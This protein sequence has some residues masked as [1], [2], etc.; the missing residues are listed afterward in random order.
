MSIVH[1]A[2]KQVSW[3]ALFKLVSQIFSWLSTIIVARL[4]LPDDYGLMEMATIF[5]GY[6]AMFSELGLG[7]AIIQRTKPTQ[8]QLSS[9]FWFTAFI[10]LFFSSSCFVLAYPTAFIFHE[11]RVIPLTQ[12]V[13]VI[14]LTDGLQIV[15]LS[16][17]KKELN[18]KLLGLIEMWSV[19]ISCISMITIGYL[20]G[21]VWTLLYGYITRSFTKLILIFF[22][23]KWSPKF[24]FEYKEVKD[25]IKFGVVVSLGRSLNYM[26]EKS[27]RFFAARAWSSKVLGQYAFAFQLAQLPTEKIVSLITQVSM[28]VFAQLQND[29]IN[30]NDFYLNVNKAI[31]SFVLPLFFGGFL[32]G[33]DLIKIVLGEKWIPITFLFRV[34]CLSQ[35]FMG[36]SSI[37]NTTNIAQGRPIWNMY[38]TGAC[39][40]LMSVSFFIAV[41]YGLNAILI[42]WLTIYPTLCFILLIATINK[43]G[44]NI[45]QYLFNVITP[46]T[47][48]VAMTIS[49]YFCDRILISLL[50]EKIISVF[51]LLIKIITGGGTYIGVYLIL[52]KKFIKK[53][54]T[55]IKRDLNK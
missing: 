22:F 43:I 12:M 21:G 20:N 38:F 34:L 49:I 19:F 52:D 4:L 2:F 25:F 10:S 33:E 40:I 48:I 23:Q 32:L 8:H 51:T 7:S 53:F 29:K 42:P 11:P 1:K 3:L 41:Q 18:F 30:F 35:I 46:F 6:A 54:F 39:A 26:F 47:A 55:M 9:L 31:I 44:I 13:S 50:D 45:K 36:I 16:L 5:T 15:P 24:S 28:P 17:M 37:N 14:F 27:D